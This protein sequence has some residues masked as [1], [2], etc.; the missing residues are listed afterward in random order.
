MEQDSY[1]TKILFRTR[2]LIWL[3][4]ILL[5]LS[6]QSAP[7]A[8]AA[9]LVNDLAD[10]DTIDGNCTLREAITA[11]NQ[12]ADYGDCRQRRLW[13]RHNQIPRQRYDYPRRHSAG[14]HRFGPVDHKR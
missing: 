11:A 13:S 6:V 7:A 5:A 10:S 8:Q 14:G 2:D 3:G 12:D 4:S 9:S 1:R